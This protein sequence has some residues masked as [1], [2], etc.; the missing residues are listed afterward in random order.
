[1]SWDGRRT[2]LA[3]EHQGRHHKGRGLRLCFRKI[4]G[5]SKE[6]GLEQPDCKGAE[7]EPAGER[8]SVPQARPCRVVEGEGGD[9]TPETL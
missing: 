9:L 8:C 6:S 3:D 7:A 2:S 4:P 1:M 5:S